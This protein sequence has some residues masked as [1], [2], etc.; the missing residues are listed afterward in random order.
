MVRERRRGPPSTIQD[1]S[2]AHT[3]DGA[4]A[5]WTPADAE[6]VTDTETLAL[7]RTAA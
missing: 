3:L 5:A 2:L 1:Y 6:G 4:Q 7:L